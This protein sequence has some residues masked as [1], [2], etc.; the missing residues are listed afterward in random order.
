MKSVVFFVRDFAV[1]VH[2]LSLADIG[3]VGDIMTL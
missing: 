1:I 2:W 3:W